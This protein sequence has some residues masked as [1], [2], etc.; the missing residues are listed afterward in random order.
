[1]RGAS[2]ALDGFDNGFVV[3]GSGGDIWGDADT[4]TFAYDEGMKVTGDFDAQVQIMSFLKADGTQPCEWGR[5]GFMARENTG[6]GAPYAFVGVNGLYR[7]L[8]YSVRRCRERLAGR[9][10][11][12]TRATSTDPRQRDVPCLDAPDPDWQHVLV[13]LQAERGR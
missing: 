4:F 8:S 5:A 13:L 11:G 10:S 9:S 2:A 7:P 12:A 1:V 3:N 6:N